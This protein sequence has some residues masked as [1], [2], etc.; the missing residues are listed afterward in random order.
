M[1]YIAAAQGMRLH[2]NRRRMPL[3]L[4][5]TC[6]HI[7]QAEVKS[8]M[9]ALNNGIARRHVL[10]AL[11]EAYPHYCPYEVLQAAITDEVLNHACATVHRA[12]EHRILDR[13]MKPFRNILSRCRDKLYAFGI[14]I[15]SI[16]AEGYILT[17]LRCY[18]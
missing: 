5:L 9:N 11:L 2:R 7:L 18:P 6:T 10:V 12:V 17:A 8:E 3:A 1:R 4:D 14:D 13:S 15:H 16:H